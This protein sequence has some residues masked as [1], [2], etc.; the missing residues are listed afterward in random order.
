MGDSIRAH[1]DTVDHDFYW[2]SSV[3]EDEI[4]VSYQKFKRVATP[5]EDLKEDEWHSVKTMVDQS[6]TI[7]SLPKGT[8]FIIS[9][10]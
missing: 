8:H 5:W 9:F 3:V 10:I 1:Y 2:L 7:G 4:Q 6:L